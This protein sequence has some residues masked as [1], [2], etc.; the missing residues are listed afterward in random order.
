MIEKIPIIRLNVQKTELLLQVYF[1][2]WGI[3]AEVYYLDVSLS[4]RWRATEGDTALCECCGSDCFRQAEEE[5]SEHTVYT[6]QHDAG[7]STF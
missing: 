6:P 4:F 1:I 2:S 7:C 3:Q 5:N